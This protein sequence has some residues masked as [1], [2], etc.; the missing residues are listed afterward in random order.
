MSFVGSLFGDFLRIFR[1]GWL[2][3]GGGNRGILTLVYEW[4]KELEEGLAFPCSGLWAP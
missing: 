4:I 3:G 2:G 1:I